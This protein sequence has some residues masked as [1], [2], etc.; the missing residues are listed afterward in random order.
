MQA[1]QKAGNCQE[2]LHRQ[3]SMVSQ[4]ASKIEKYRGTFI[5]ETFILERLSSWQAHM[6]RISGYLK[7][8]EGAWWERSENGFLFHDGE[9]DPDFCSSGPHLDH[10][11]NTT[12]PDIYGR[13]TQDWGIIIGGKTELPSPSVRIY[14]ENG[15][16]S[17]LHRA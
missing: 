11:R 6:M 2:S 1:R 7:Q 3:E 12:L 16:T 9:D 13:M 14:S 8:G 17:T 10:F 5:T 15:N 4:A